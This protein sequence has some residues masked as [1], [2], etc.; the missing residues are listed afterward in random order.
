M[1]GEWMKKINTNITIE[2]IDK[3][4]KHKKLMKKR[5]KQERKNKFR[6]NILEIK[7]KIAIVR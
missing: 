1:Y 5:M 6:E 3:Y 2:D 7:Q 4:K